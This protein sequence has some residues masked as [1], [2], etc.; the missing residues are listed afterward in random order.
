M[1]S[2]VGNICE[3]LLTWFL[4]CYKFVRL[5][6][7]LRYGCSVRYSIFLGVLNMA[8]IY[9]LPIHS[10]SSDAQRAC[11]TVIAQRIYVFSYFL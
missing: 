3:H 6:D 8:T 10:I 7:V 11:P 5:A 2:H 4:L 9:M 1:E